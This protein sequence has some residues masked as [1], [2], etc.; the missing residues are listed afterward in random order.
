[1]DKDT[2]LSKATNIKTKI[3]EFIA[4]GFSASY[5]LENGKLRN[6][7]TNKS[8]G[9]NDLNIVDQYVSED[10]SNPKDQST[11]YA[12]ETKEG[13]KGTVLLPSG[14]NADTATQE[15]IKTLCKD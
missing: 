3:D 14:P 1:M 4:K 9:P 6:L 7:K 8:Y 12:I 15:F 10:S 5:K 11:M 13:C 2:E